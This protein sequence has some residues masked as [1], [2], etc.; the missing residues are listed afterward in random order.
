MYAQCCDILKWLQFNSIF[1]FFRRRR[2]FSY[3]LK[4]A[5][6]SN[7]S[8]RVRFMHFFDFFREV[9]KKIVYLPLAQRYRIALHTLCTMTRTSKT[10][11]NGLSAPFRTLK[12]NFFFQVHEPNRFD[13]NNLFSCCFF[14]SFFYYNLQM[15]NVSFGVYMIVCFCFAFPFVFYSFFSFSCVYFF[16]ASF[17]AV[18]M[19]S[20]IMCFY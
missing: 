17:P 12:Y 13:K 19:L 5:E 6:T 14:F 4:Q 1:L 8:S 18:C 20:T 10:I 7:Q 11:I 16:H 3:S 15:E 2:F 9:R